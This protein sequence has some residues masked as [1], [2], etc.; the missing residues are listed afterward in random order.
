MFRLQCMGY[1][2]LR[3]Y[4]IRMMSSDTLLD[5][6][7]NCRN[8]DHVFNIVGKYKA[9][10]SVKHVGC[11][12]SMLW[13]FQ[14]EKP[15]LLRT[16]EFVKNHPQF[17]ALR[18]LAENKIESMDDDTLVDM[19]YNALRLSVE[20]SD[21]LIEELII[22]G[23]NRIE[24]FRM[25][26]LSK[27]A[28]CLNDQHLHHSPL[29]GKIADIV[30]RK[31]DF[32]QNIRV[33]STLMVSISAVISPHLQDR[34]IEKAESLL[35][36]MDPAQY[37][38][39]RRITQFL[40]N[41][42]YSHRPLLEKCNKVFL[43]NIKELDAENF[44]IILGLYQSLQFNNCEFRL[45]AKKRLTQMVDSCTDPVSF[46]RLFAA[47]GPMAGLE[48]RES[49]ESA[50]LLIIE[51]LSP[52]QAVAMVETME[53][54]ECRNPQL[55]Q[56]TASVLQKY[57]GM[58]KPVDVAR[59]TQTL[60]LLHY[61][62]PEVYTKL[63]NLLVSFLKVSMIP[64]EVSMLTRV[65]SMFPSLR[66]DEE[67]TSRVDAVLPQCNLSE[68]NSFALAIAK[69]I[70][71]DTS[72]R[73][74]TA[75]VYVKLLQNLNKR[76]LERLKKADNMDSLLEELKYISG[77]WF[78]DTL[79][80]ETIATCQRIMDQITWKNIHEFA[81]F[82][83]RTNYVCTSLLDR[84]ATVTLEDINKR[85][86]FLLTYPILL[87]YIIHYNPKTW[88]Y[89]FLYCM[90]FNVS[91]I[92]TFDP[93]MLVLL[94]YSLAVA[95]YFPED[96]I[97]AIFNVDFLAKLDA[98]LETL[99]DALN[100]RIR[101]RLMELNRAICLECPEFEV[102]WFHDRY[103]QQLQRKGNGCISAVQQQIHK[104][105]GE[106]L[107]GISYSKVAPLTPYYYIIDFECI[108]DK[109]K[110][111]LPYVGQNTLLFS[112]H[113]KVQWGPQS[114]A[115]ERKGL[116]PGSE[117]RVALEFLDYKAFC[118]NSHHI[119]G[120][121]MMKKRHLEILGY[122]VVQI[123]HFEWNSMELS[124]KDAWVEYLRK[125]IFAEVS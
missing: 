78:E 83:T 100:V 30:S 53:E 90:K 58:Y 17:L 104:M 60:L 27:F 52:Q 122:H 12:F 96:L 103:C 39:P 63:R 82:L 7:S 19:L 67:V 94:G 120:E 47:L 117:R 99:P 71:N 66:V 61:Q 65:L 116:P 119:K 11:A 69:W 8:E 88:E 97:R 25:S 10:I 108:L 45:A 75:G 56:K 6:L 84:I 31:L 9:K 101:L 111:P 73:Y 22:E 1:L 86:N 46:T 20:P 93:H 37:N 2:P 109:Q 110:R 3:F 23:W 43:Q 26:T 105:L 72:Y 89:M 59:I 80:L 21:S 28:V 98:Q 123:P 113:E 5:Q 121:A 106:I 112:E 70:R 41:V 29:M 49:L 92:Y 16:T 36:V 62:N 81:L 79:L 14:K 51:D 74:S 44:S 77:E 18:I 91:N 118:K 42:K 76:G 68:L 4:S 54:M 95:N 87:T 40:R 32:V 38:S 114:Q 64:C 85:I 24:G 115:L 124:T 125:K 107:G 102:P 33:L 13:Q 34:L 48:T 55:I 50:A 35:E 15:Q 57:L